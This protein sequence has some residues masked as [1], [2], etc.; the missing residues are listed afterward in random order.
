[1]GFSSGPQSKKHLFVKNKMF[2]FEQREAVSS[3]SKNHLC[4]HP[5][6]P[7]SQSI[8]QVSF[9]SARKIADLRASKYNFYA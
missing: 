1:M 5:S 9:L 3:L 4:F 8:G 2:L 7:I 6:Q